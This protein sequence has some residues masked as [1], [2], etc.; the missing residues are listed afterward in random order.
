MQTLELIEK[1][2]SI[3][4]T[5]PDS[6]KTINWSEVE[7]C[8]MAELKLSGQLYCTDQLN[9]IYS[10]IHDLCENTRI[11]SYAAD[12]ISLQR[13]LAV[14]KGI[15]ISIPASD[16][17]NSF[18]TKAAFDKAA[19]DHYRNDTTVVLGDSHVNFFSG[20]EHLNFHPIGHDIDLCPQGN[21]MPFTV[22]YLGPC[23]AYTCLDKSSRTKFADKLAYLKQNFIK[24]AAGLILSLGEIDIRVHVI[25]QAEKQ[26]I[27]YKDVIDNILKNYRTLISHLL[28]EGYRVSC[29]G[30][31]ATQKDSNPE[32]TSFPRYG[33]EYERNLATRYFNV[34][35]AEICH[36]ESAGFISIYNELTDDN[37]LT[38]QE[39]LSDDNFHLSQ[40]A[41]DLAIPAFKNAG[42]I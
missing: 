8:L 14:L 32:D 12:R 25:K 15:C 38:R 17:N 31:I 35:L 40:S 28:S 1:L 10:R 41:M 4:L 39:Y 16:D 37:G 26:N 24:P 5:S 23:L 9:S 22:L 20:Q 33:S 18:I 30:P 2:E 29:W 36:E 19:L 6:L 42:I 7:A 11:S 13:S 34:R 27:S 3:A 21:N